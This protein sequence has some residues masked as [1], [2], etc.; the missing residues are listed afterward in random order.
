MGVCADEVEDVLRAI[1]EYVSHYLKNPTYVLDK[2]RIHTSVRW[3]QL[4]A[5][6]HPIKP[7]L[8]PRRSPDFN[9][10][11]EHFIKSVKSEFKKELR[12]CDVRR[13][14]V[15]YMHMLTRAY[16]RC[17]TTQ[18][19]QAINKDILTL[20]ALWSHVSTARPAGSAGDWPPAR[21]R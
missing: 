17:C 19:T 3:Q 15:A 5:G 9:R 20:P 4:A 11:A 21:F 18:M 16:K 14:P 13:E 2:P 10:P 12:M 1:H 8:H 7:A 6:P